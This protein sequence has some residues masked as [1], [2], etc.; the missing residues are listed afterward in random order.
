MRVAPARDTPLQRNTR[1][2]RGWHTRGMPDLDELARRM[3]G[4]VSELA[5]KGMMVATGVAVLVLLIGGA[6]YLTGLAALDGSARSA[7]TLVGLAMLIA[8]IAAP[9][10]A[11]W[12]L[13]RVRRHVDE[14]VGEVRTLITTEPDAQRVVIETI[15]HDEQPVQR[16]DP[17]PVVYDSR[18]FS[19]LRTASAGV[20]GMRQLP[21]AL[22]AVTTFPALLL[23]ALVGIVVFGILGFLFMIAWVLG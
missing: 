7:W 19:R 12:R 16:G 6:S 2:G 22:L 8:A 1:M 17:L 23:W 4:L 13:R 9:L 15:A 14:L 11:G 21:G 20:G 10:I 5:R 18:Q 3:T